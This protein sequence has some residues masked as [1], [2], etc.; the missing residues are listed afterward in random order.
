MIIDEEQRFGVDQR[1]ALMAKGAACD[2]LEMT[3]TP[4]P[5]TLAL[6]LYGSMTQS[7]LREIPFERP[8]RTT[9]V[10]GFRERGRAYDVALEAC[11]RGEQA[12]I[13]CPLVGSQ[14]GAAAPSFWVAP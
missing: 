4:I 12:Y 11:K 14:G 1:E 3:A 5:R 2:V 6:A 13:V 7:Y 9:K 10:Y 8:P